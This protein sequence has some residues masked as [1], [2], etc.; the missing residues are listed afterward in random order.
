MEEYTLFFCNDFKDHHAKSFT[1][2][3]YLTD[4]D[5]DE[6]FLATLVD[7]HKVTVPNQFGGVDEAIALKVLV[8]PKD[9]ANRAPESQVYARARVQ[10]DEDQRTRR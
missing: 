6:T 2:Y 3:G 8:N 1:D 7:G 9:V 4:T 10:V 5:D